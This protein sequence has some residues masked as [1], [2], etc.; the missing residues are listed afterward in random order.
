MSAK[1]LFI[2]AF[3]TIATL[4][5]VIILCRSFVWPD[6]TPLPTT[7]AHGATHP[8]LSLSKNT[9]LKKLAEYEQLCDGSAVDSL[10]V[11]I[12]MPT[13]K[14]E[15]LQ[16][17]STSVETL[18]EFSKHG[19]VPLVVFEPS[20]S[21]STVI[22]DIKNGLYDLA[23]QTYFSV[24]KTSGIT[25]EQMGTWV[26]FPEANTP[27]WH[28]TSPSDFTANVKKVATF[29]KEMFPNSKTSVL[30]NSWSYQSDDSSWSRGE[31]KSL[32][33]YVTDLPHSL[34]DS[35]GLQGFPY[36]AP[37]NETPMNRLTVTE[38][39]PGH[40]AREAAEKL[41]VRTIWLNTGT[42][43]HM[44]TG[45]Q[46]TEVQLSAEERSGILAAILKEATSIQ[47]D[48]FTTY[49]NLFAQDKS[50]AD[51]QVDWSYWPSSRPASESAS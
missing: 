26:P 45:S 11:F 20:F 10:M 18:T 25:D 7:C 46:E 19:I 41:G 34:I 33:P 17:A 31:P 3:I 8:E 24:L 51:E 2:G 14:E 23:F 43:S 15:A 12:A 21:S 48:K 36:K 6:A 30:L 22:S 9:S 4:S 35:F 29:Q 13:T 39:L 1:T 32:L 37:A 42:F 49:V 38:F 5:G 28:N 27:A 44:H 40:L 47:K 16:Q 50:G